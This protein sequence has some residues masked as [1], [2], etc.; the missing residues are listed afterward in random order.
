MATK[1]E[2]KHELKDIQLFE[3]NGQYYLKLKYIIED[4]Y[5]VKEIEIPKVK[6][7]FTKDTYPYINKTIC[8]RKNVWELPTN[9]CVLEV[10]GI[11]FPMALAETSESCGCAAF[12]TEKVIKEKHKEMTLA[13]IE[14]KLGYKIKIVAEE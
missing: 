3:E 14:K 5:S 6:L 7:P 12:F 11:M 13:E 2:R 1:N 4:E 9:E 10:N 8:P